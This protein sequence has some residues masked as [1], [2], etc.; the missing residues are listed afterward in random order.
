MISWTVLPA[1]INQNKIILS[2]TLVKI[3][4]FPRTL[5]F[6]RPQQTQ[7]SLRGRLRKHPGLRVKHS[8]I[9]DLSTLPFYST[10]S[11]PLCLFT[12]SIKKKK[13]KI[14]FCLTPE[15]LV[16]FILSVFLPIAVIFSNSI[17]VS[18]YLTPN[19]FIVV[20]PNV[21]TRLLTAGKQ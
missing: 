9:Y 17:L 11:Q 5:N 13:K 14:L 21:T 10:S 1:L 2:Q 4:S 20:Q 8:L 3:L 6:H 18:F 7:P 15:T 19:L 16:C 12:S